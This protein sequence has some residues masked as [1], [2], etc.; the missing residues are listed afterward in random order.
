MVVQEEG[1]KIPNL[2]KMMNSM[3]QKVDY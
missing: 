3:M 1:E 2:M